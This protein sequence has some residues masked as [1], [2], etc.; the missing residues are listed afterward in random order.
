MSNYDNGFAD[1]NVYGH[2]AGLVASFTPKSG[3]YFLDFGCGFGRMAETLRDRHGLHY[4]GC[5]INEPGLASLSERGFQTGY[6]DLSDTAAAL[7]L[8]K[9]IVP[10]SATVCGICA[11]DTLE[12]LAEPLVALQF[13]A[14]L[15]R[16]Y[17]AP[18]FISVP[19]VGHRDI[20]ARLAIGKFEY[21]EAGLLDHTHL[22]Y[23]TNDRLQELMA[24]SGWHEVRRADVHME[25]SDQ[26]FPSTL[27]LLSA[28]SPIGR[29]TGALRDQADEYAKV[30]Q[31][32][33]AYLR[34][35]RVEVA[36]NLPYIEQR[37]PQSIF[38]S[39]IVRTIGTRIGTLRESLLCLSAQS[40]QDFEVLVIGH[41]LDV[42]RQVAVEEVIEELHDSM[43]SRTRLV[44]LTGGSRAAPL[45]SGFAEASGQYVVAFD[46]DDL[47][48]GNWVEK[49]HELAK[50]NPGQ[51]LRL[52]A[53]AQDWDRVGSRG[54]DP[55]S[56]AISGIKALYPERFDLVAHIVENRTPLH[57]IAFPRTLYSE[58]NYRFDP[59]LSTA[60]DWD[61]IIRVSQVAGV[62]CSSAIGCIYRLW[63]CG[64]NSAAAHDQFEWSSNYL[65][66]LR[67]IDDLPLLLPPGSA[68]KVR[69][70]FTELERL[71]IP[72][73]VRQEDPASG[74][75]E[76]DDAARLEQLRQRYHELVTSKSWR[77]SSPLRVLKHMLRR[78]PWPRDLQIWRMNERDLDH[79]IRMILQSSSWRWTALVRQLRR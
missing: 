10:A 18:L 33:R 58:M 38:L 67:K 30:N 78:Q 69:R 54:L 1:D 64:D 27:P 15:S 49:F 68:I 65:R 21:T 53:V 79:H 50:N 2:I 48:F 61:F 6:L 25:R 72:L 42:E 59:Q 77:L 34:G 51:L 5:D 13:F 74:V 60:E 46:D 16:L 43:R 23:F 9:E 17:G 14:E 29:L 35:P 37:E 8:V 39:V 47:L 57:S 22:Q 71:H 63:K 41:N 32:V 62:A 20:S 52:T 70:M 31:F 19:N 12:H 66:T 40:D 28:K 24:A 56:R 3:E 75:L 76:I 55:A 45:N 73:D 26:H 7:A 36:P 44:R 4:V 11:I